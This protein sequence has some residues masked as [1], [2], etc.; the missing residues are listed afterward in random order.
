MSPMNRTTPVFPPMS[1][2]VPEEELDPLPAAEPVAPAI[3]RLP[4]WIPTPLPLDPV[5]LIEKRRPS[6]LDLR[7]QSMPRRPRLPT[8]LSFSRLVSNSSKP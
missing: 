6:M 8:N 5:L 3:T 4:T 1:R 7:S 2:E